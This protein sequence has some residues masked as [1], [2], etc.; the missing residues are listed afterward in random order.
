[1]KFLNYMNLK[2]NMEGEEG[3]DQSSGTAEGTAEGTSDETAEGT[4]EGTSDETT[5]ETTDGTADGTADETSDETAEE[6]PVETALNDDF[7]KEKVFT[8]S[9][10]YLLLF[11]IV[12]YIVAYFVLGMFTGQGA[13]SREITF[14]Y[15]IDL[16]LATV[17]I[18]AFIAFYFSLDEA[19]QDT[20]LKE[21][22]E[23]VKNYIKDDYAWIYQLGYILILYTMIYI[24]RIPMKGGAKPVSIY[25]LETVGWLLFML[26]LAYMLFKVA[27]DV[28]LFDDFEKIF[29]IPDTT[30]PETPPEEE[31]NEGV[32]PNE[33]S[34]NTAPVDD[35]PKKE[36]FNF[37]NNKYNYEDAQAIC[38]AYGAD[39]ATYDQIEESYNNG[40]EWCNYGW[41]ANQMAYFPTQ[42]ETWNKL[43]STNKHKNACGRPG[44][45]GGYMANPNIKFGVNCYG[46]KPEAKKCNLDKLSTSGPH[47]PMTEEEKKMDEKVQYWKE[48]GD[49]CLNMNSFNYNKWSKGN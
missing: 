44:I 39:I 20:F 1:M 43:Q 45:N 29:E 4:A 15:I 48:N 38:K 26:I 25:V 6:V 36:V 21:R 17:F 30:V 32:P 24:F 5:D 34:E 2:E 23:S 13:S 9:N 11:F 31:T 19:K 49:Q 12:I 7:L 22:W 14:S 35:G 41:S 3:A 18:A 37:S 47:I 42:K 46:V 28:S 8:L 10:L 16:L 27:F 33:S 40:G